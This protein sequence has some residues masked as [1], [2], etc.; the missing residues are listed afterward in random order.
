MG[1]LWRFVVEWDYRFSVRYFLN[2]G[3]LVY[4]I[5][6]GLLSFFKILFYDRYGIFLFRFLI[7]L[8]L[9]RWRSLWL[10]RGLEGLVHLLWTSME[11]I[12]IHDFVTFLLFL[13]IQ[14]NT[15]TDSK[16]L[17]INLWLIILLLLFHHSQLLFNQ[18]QS[19]HIP[20]ILLCSDTAIIFID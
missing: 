16:S 10:L 14:W 19:F 9:G 13:R 3:I 5:Y 20:V 1:K 18:C 7:I 2:L 15:G 17:S 4:C 8:F 12:L 11:N 6:D